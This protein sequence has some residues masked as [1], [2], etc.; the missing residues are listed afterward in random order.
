MK[1]LIEQYERVVAAHPQNIAIEEE[2][3]RETKK[4]TH[5]ELWNLALRYAGLLEKNIPPCSLVELFMQKSINYVAAI[6][7][8]WMHGCYFLPI[9]PTLPKNRIKFI[10]EDSKP[11]FTITE[12]SIPPTKIIQKI[13]PLKDSDPAYIIYTSGSSGTPKGVLVSHQGLPYVI[14]E[15]IKMFQL[16]QE[17]RVFFFLS[18]CFDASLSDILTTLIA[19]ATLVI[20]RKPNVAERLPQILNTK[21]ITHI[22]LPPSLLSFL[23]ES[24]IPPHL[25]TIIIGGESPPTEVLKRIALKVNVIN[26]YGPT[27]T[28]ICTSMIK[29]DPQTWKGP[30]IGHPINGTKYLVLNEEKKEIS[31]GIGELYITGVQVAIGYHNLPQLNEERF[32]VH[33]GEGTYKTGDLVRVEKDGLYFIGRTD[34]QVKVRGQLVALE[35]IEQT[36][37]S[38][39]DIRRCAVIYKNNQL[40][41]FIE[42]KRKNFNPQNLKIFLEKRLP[43]YMVPSFQI[44]N[45][46]PTLSNGKVNYFA[47]KS[48]EKKKISSKIPTTE[49]DSSP[50]YTLFE[51]LWKEVLKKKNIQPNDNFFEIGGNSLA[52]LELVMKAKKNG[53]PL[54]INTIA[55]HPTLAALTKT[56]RNT[57][58]SDGI[59]VKELRKYVPLPKRISGEVSSDKDILITGASGFLGIYSLIKLVETKRKIHLIIRSKDKQSALKKLSA[60][61]KSFGVDLP[62]LS[63]VEIHLG[64][65]THEKMGLKEWDKLTKTVSDVYHLAAQVNMAK[66]LQEL[67]P[68]NVE[69]L[70]NIITYA[71]TGILKHI[72]YASTLSVFVATDNNRGIFKEGSSIDDC[73]L[74]YGGYAQTKWIAEKILSQSLLPHTIY[75]FGLLTGNSK[76]GISSSHDYLTMFLRGIKSL[77]FIPDGDDGDKDNLSMDITPID[78]AADLFVNLSLLRKQRIYHITSTKS[79]TLKQIKEMLCKEGVQVIPIDQWNE[80]IAKK[81]LSFEEN[82]AVMALCR[83][84]NT[85]FEHFRGM[86]LFQSTDTNFDITNVVRELP[87]IKIPEVNQKLLTLYFK[88]T[89]S[90]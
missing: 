82:A 85:D 53:I 83:L 21:R 10:R 8:C 63:N 5:E 89:S 41:A 59:S 55:N 33:N 67:Y 3:K 35:E 87:N 20:D 78:F 62:D 70:Q 32:I 40:Q 46:L 11:S 22:D 17:S 79:F 27:E 29:C 57:K 56:I 24:G 47:L 39:K 4:I 68:D 34:R 31:H 65:L 73:N 42:L 58:L 25:E 28:T 69:A 52:V 50:L 84:S 30:H 26:V 12:E 61:A 44:V 71:S 77:G 37:I 38:H 51:R 15:Q 1:N 14:N 72:H 74:V 76:T 45:D 66:S 81:E 54:A 6:L 18:I 9:S 48:D 13:V 75:R 80:F 19:G 16:Q 88:R 86:D 43:P 49:K 64:D 36:I 2:K 23:M 7:G 60:S 90:K